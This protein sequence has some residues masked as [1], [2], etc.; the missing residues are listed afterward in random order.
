MA[1]LDL[2][3]VDVPRVL[4][5]LTLHAYRLWGLSPNGTGEP[6]LSG[7]G[8]SPED[9]AYQTVMLLLTPHQHLWKQAYGV[10][11][12]E[13]VLN[14]LRT[15]MERDFIDMVRR[16]AHTT[17]VAIE[18]QNDPDGHP[19]TLDAYASALF[20]CPEGAALRTLER[21]RL[22]A[23]V[24]GDR[25]LEDLMRILLNPAEYGVEKNQE[26]ATLFPG[27]TASDIVNLRRR[28]DTAV[29]RSWSRPSGR[30]SDG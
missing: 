28:L 3:R 8:V 23:C 30:R 11:T 12:T 26:I 1:E 10:P 14:F 19:L 6:V 27:K 7:A 25:D 24:K 15:V 4:K 2:S 5:L 9:L 29:R 21:E 17:T 22:L 13:S 20:E 16:K 18:Q